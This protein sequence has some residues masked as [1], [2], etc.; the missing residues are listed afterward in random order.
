MIGAA[1]LALIGGEA[2]AGTL[3]VAKAKAEID[4]GLDADYPEL[5]A[6]Y[7]DIHSHPELGFQE[8]R[9]AALLAARMRA[10][11]FAVTEHVGGTGVVAIYKNGPGP[12]VL[13]RTELDALPMEEKTG[14]S[15]ASTAKQTW[16][17]KET[18]VDHSCGH[19]S[20][21]AVW[22]GT[23]KALI[24]M[25]SQ[26]RGTLMF[27]GQPSEETV[28]G[29]K[30][31]LADHLYER[32]GKPDYGFA[33]HVGPDAYGTI[34][35]RAGVI[36]SNSDGLEIKFL[37]RGGHGSMPSATIDPIVMAGHFIVDVQSVV[38]REKDPM[39]FGVV[40]IGA[41]QGG[42]AGN[43]I[44][45]NVIL[46]GTIRSYSPTVRQGLITGIERTA[47]AVADMAGAPP[48]VVTITAGG[49]AVVNDPALTARTA[50]VLKA[51]FG[52]K[53]KET[54]GPS[55][56]SED[57]SEFV[58]AGVPST[59]LSLGGYDP[60]RIAEAKLK[61]LPLPVNHSPYFYPIP[62]PTIRT[63]VEAMTLSVL[64]VLTPEVG[65]SARAENGAINF[66]GLSMPII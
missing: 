33:L 44:P 24:A 35:Y 37:G 43:I 2:Q 38:S 17:G 34:G 42:S 41:V 48:P 5:D 51:A 58:L 63:G 31:M 61:G 9:T 12:L 54:P 52:D 64:N 40:T 45:D 1:L 32:F 36:T 39:A 55:S 15:Y 22:V 59:F 60:A 53:A 4:Q 10:L 49:N 7:K 19:D 8:N 6:L 56:A 66:D 28:G 29:A 16:Q 46:R 21:M 11:G 20:H 27:I 26:W 3:D 14:L 13:V 57:F 25:K 23:A 62:E 30:A 50:L 47:K 65:A 18:F